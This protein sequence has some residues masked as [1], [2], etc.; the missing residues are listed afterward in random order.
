MALF[1]NIDWTAII[2]SIKLSLVTTVLLLFIA[3]PTAYLLT[4][5]SFKGKAIINA[6]FAMPLVIPPTV[7]GFILLV[8]TGANSPIGKLYLDITGS[9][10]AFS[11]TGLV[12]ASIVYSLP[13]ALQPIQNSFM[14]IDSKYIETSLTLGKDKRR[15]FFKVVLP[16]SRDGILTGALLAF[17]HTMGEFGVVLMIGGSIPGVTKVASISIYENVETLNYIGAGAMSGLMILISLAILSLVY[18]IKGKDKPCLLQ[19]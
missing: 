5:R 10:L 8:S 11:F 13:F 2:L 18:S 12:V 3:I 9:T 16:L 17:A 4:F 19:K 7:L 1:N 14:S 15:T 6:L